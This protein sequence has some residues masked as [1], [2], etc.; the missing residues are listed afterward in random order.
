MTHPAFLRPATSADEDF[1]W[2]VYASTRA[3]EIAAWGWPAQ[4][5]ESFLRM[6]FRARRASYAISH[7]GA[8]ESILIEGDVP[9]G[10]LIVA[11]S[12][13]EIRLVDIAFLP[14][15][16]GR[17]LGAQVLSDLIRESVAASLPFRLSVARGNPALRL[18][19]RLG[20]VPQSED[21]MYIEME[22]QPKES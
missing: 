6:Q 22:Y 8:Q 14:E 12:P 21:A 5:Q 1:L 4:Q 16:R 3:D 9:I 18:Y 2:R 17:G 11:R 13:G 10:I 15:Y 19:L 7:A 20:L